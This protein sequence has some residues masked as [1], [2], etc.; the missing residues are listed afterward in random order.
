[1]GD[2][3]EVEPAVRAEAFGQPMPSE[4]HKGGADGNVDPEDPVPTCGVDDRAPQ[5]RTGRDPESGDPTPKPDGDT[6][7][8]GW[9]GVADQRETE[10]HDS[11]GPTALDGSGGDEQ[12]DVRGES[13][14]RRAE[15]E[16]PDAA[17][18]DAAPPETITE[19]GGGQKP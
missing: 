4:R 14:Q 3:E 13:G 1:M 18:E 12:S 15:S 5:D 8:F 11:G 16:Q 2:A 17:Q 6:T 7:S 19:R 9:E 10:G